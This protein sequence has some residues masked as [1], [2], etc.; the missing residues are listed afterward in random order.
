MPPP[1][2]TAIKP[3]L[4]QWILDTRTWYPEATETR[5]L[6][7]HA[8]RALALLTDPERRGVLKYFH[9]RDAKMA[10]ASALLKHLV[11]SKLAPV[12]WRSSIITRDERTKPVFR[13]PATGYSPVS[14]NVSHQAGIVALV[15][16]AHYPRPYGAAEVGVD[17]VC[18][19]ERRDRDLRIL[20]DESEGW[21]SFVDMH[22]DVFAPAETAYLK[23]QV[24]A[25]IPG[26][27]PPKATLDQIAD[28]KLRAFYALWAL[29]E[30][31][32]KLTGE[33][34][35]ADWLRELEF[36]SFRPPRSTAAWDVP[37]DG[38]NFSGDEDEARAQVIRKVDIYFHGEKLDDVNICLRSMGPDYMIC[39]VVR[40][41]DR[42]EDA[43]GWK[44]GPYEILDLDEVLDFA[45]SQV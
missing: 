39:T 10:L 13:D 24:L 41:P 3:V 15:A 22:A 4:V 44:L 9:V 7:T 14:F 31:Y 34:L 6:E 45:E 23:Y 21:E 37:P 20:R 25:A 1:T 33:A 29:R 11:V 18:T 30:A 42:K 12:P 16:V 36:R 38:E 28:G 19:S 8:S 5:Q 17:V 40:T 43:L 26:L 2:A 27:I 35:L 32:V